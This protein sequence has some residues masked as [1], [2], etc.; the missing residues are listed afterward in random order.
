MKIKTQ[1]AQAEAAW[2]QADEFSHQY[3]RDLQLFQ[4]LEMLHLQF[5]ASST[6]TSVRHQKFCKNVQK[7]TMINRSSYKHTAQE[8]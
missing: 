3:T 1:G 7:E 2:P 6:S 4:D 5:V 8:L